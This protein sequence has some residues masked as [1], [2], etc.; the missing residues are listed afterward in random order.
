[1]KVLSLAEANAIADAQPDINHAPRFRYSDYEG[2]VF[3]CDVNEIVTQTKID[4]C[5]NTDYLYTIMEP[6]QDIFDERGYNL[7]NW[8]DELADAMNRVANEL[9]LKD[10]FLTKETDSVNQ[11]VMIPLYKSDSG[12]M[13]FTGYANY[14]WQT[15]FTNNDGKVTSY[16]RRM[17]MEKSS[18]RF[19][20][21]RDLEQNIGA[22]YTK[23]VMC[24]CFNKVRTH[25]VPI[26]HARPG[27][28]NGWSNRKNVCISCIKYVCKDNLA[29]QNRPHLR[30]WEGS[31]GF[32]GI[33]QLFYNP[34]RD[35]WS[36]ND[37]WGGQDDVFENANAEY[38]RFFRKLDEDT[39]YRIRMIERVD[40]PRWNFT[41]DTAMHQWNY[42]FPVRLVSVDENGLK[43]SD[44]PNKDYMDYEWFYE[45][46]PFYGMEFE[47]FVRNDRSDYRDSTIVMQDA[48]RMF[49]HTDYPS[50]W[51]MYDGMHQLIYR[52]S[53]GS[54]REGVGVEFVSQPL[55]YDYW[56]KEIPDRFWDYFQNNFRAMNSTECGIHIHIGWDSMQVAERYVFLK[57]LNEL[58]RSRSPLLAAIAG[59]D[60]TYYATWNTLFYQGSADT[61]FMVAMEKRQTDQSSTPKYNAINTLHDSTI[62][63]RYFQGNTGRKS[64]LGIVQFVD[65]IYRHAVDVIH[66]DFHNEGSSWNYS[67]EGPRAFLQGQLEK[68]NNNVDEYLLNVLSNYPKDRINYLLHRLQM[69]DYELPENI[70]I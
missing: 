51:E 33:D 46:G 2:L 36:W 50:G 67:Q 58:N 3:Q 52:K 43:E 48:I 16:G 49:H 7:F 59:R 63:L 23:C 41:F 45:S 17:A 4:N 57:I 54:L 10:W 70:N 15:Y 5:N 66:S 21:V 25:M 69:A 12:D 60:S 68:I 26:R 34:S 18:S 11:G 6:Y 27:I 42:R 30:M 31:V 29:S 62:E 64:I 32:D 9:H 28:R 24:L 39:I 1:M 8:L 35:D 38:K 13:L 56:M 19:M 53:D 14:E 20:P 37:T 22:R 61:A 47:C 55:S 65:L 44:S 40:I